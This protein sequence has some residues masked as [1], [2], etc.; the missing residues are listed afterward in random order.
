NEVLEN[1][2]ASPFA[3]FFDISWHA[4]HRPDLQDKIVLPIL[5][6]PYGKVLESRLL[7]LEYAS[8]V[9]SVYYYDHRFPV[10]PRS[11]GLVLGYRLDELERRLGAESPALIEYHSILTAIGHLPRRSERDVAKIAERQREKEVIKRRLATL[12]QESAP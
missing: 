2:P 11:Y 1:G 4:S 3:G 8:G 7:R 12:T 9:F 6:D 10:A 5:G